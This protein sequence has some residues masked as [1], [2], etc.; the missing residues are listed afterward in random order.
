MKKLFYSLFALA[1][2]AMTLTSCEDVPEP[3][4][5]PN[6]N[7]G[8]GE[9]V[10]SVVASGTGT[11]TDPFNVA[12]ANKYIKDGGSE[13]AEVYVKGK[14]VS[15]S[16][17]LTYG[18]ATYYISDDGTATK[19]FEVYRGYS[20]GEKKF[21]SSDEIKAGDEVVVCGK[22]VNYSGTYELTQGNYLYSLNGTTA[23][24]GGTTGEGSGEGTQTSPYN[25]AK[26]LSLINSK[27]NTSDKVYVSGTISK[28][29][30]VDTS[31]GNAIYYISDDG[32]TTTQLEVYRGYGLGG[33]KFTSESEIKVGDKVVIYGVLT[34]Y[35]T[36]PE[37]TTGSQIYSLNGST[38]GGNTGGNT[39]GTTTGKDMTADVIVSGK[40]GSVDL[41]ENSYGSQSTTDES[42]W[43]TWAFNNITY[44]GVKICKATSANGGGIQMQG[45][46]SD[47]T[48]QGFLFNSVAYSSD[49]KT[50]TLILKVVSSS[51]Y[52]PSYSLYAGTAAN[53]KV[54]AITANSTNAT[55]GSFKVYTDT[56]DLSGGSY[57][58]FTISNDKVGAIYIDK[59]VV[60]L[61]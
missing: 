58:Y 43:Y 19:K 26:A 23:G 32:A 51:T 49:I 34:L 30:K 27:T 15:A 8:G 29:D 5:N 35:G 61:K 20:L 53:P 41:G 12:G 37:I 47:A 45:N 42:T 1:M 57:K 16:I 13:T 21:A 24:G 11:Q 6:S 44:K 39:G 28:I 46:A 3:Y 55:D 48:K 17:D 18:N 59:I 2:T 14:V 9:V 31:Y 7:P 52:S 54:T 36:T 38:S 60:T 40:T 25:V 56:Y 10:D 50:I 4:N 22:L 33:N